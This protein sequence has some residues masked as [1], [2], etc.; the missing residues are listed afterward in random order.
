[1]FK[2]PNSSILA[3]GVGQLPDALAGA[4][5]AEQADASAPAAK[6]P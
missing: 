6:K 4:R 2:I 5:R 1:V 3:A